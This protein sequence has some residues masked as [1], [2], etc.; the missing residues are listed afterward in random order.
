MSSLPELPALL[1]LIKLFWKQLLIGGYALV[2]AARGVVMLIV[3]RAAL[4]WT[5]R[6]KNAV[7]RFLRFRKRI[8]PRLSH[9]HQVLVIRMMG[10]SSIAGAGAILWWLMKGM[11]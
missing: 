3:P 11:R 1:P 2:A 10:I 8:L 7:A 5:R 9:D 6:M 4:E